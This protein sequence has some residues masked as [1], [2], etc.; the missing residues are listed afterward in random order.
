MKPRYLQVENAHILYDAARLEHA[1]P[2]LFEPHAWQAQGGATSEA[3]GR[4]SVSFVRD[5]ERVYVLRHYRRGGL[6]GPLLGDHYLWTGLART[7]AWREF[8]LLAEMYRAG[9]PVPRPVAAQVV[10]AGLR[11]RADLLT[12]AIAEA[13]PLADLWRLD[14]VPDEAWPRIGACLRR[15]HRSG[16]YHADLNAH[17]VL[18]AGDQVYV[19][20]FDRG[21]R[22]PPGAWQARNLQRLQRSLRKLAPSDVEGRLSRP[23]QAL[24][25]GYRADSAP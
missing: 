7:R 18:L 15:F 22:R 16:I 5:V 1:A 23:W 3:R 25:A 21:R 14:A 9:L 20:D 17:N 2:S 13:R 24:L 11:Y 8:Q 10:R 19:L 6:F 4:G 12:E